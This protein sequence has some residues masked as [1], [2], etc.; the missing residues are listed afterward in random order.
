MN[1]TPSAY[2]PLFSSAFVFSLGIF[3][4]LRYM[5][6][7]RELELVLSLF[8]GS[9]TVWLFGTFMMFISTTDQ[10]AIFWDR[11]VYSGVVFVPTLMHHFSI[12]FADLKKQ[13]KYLKIGYI[14]SFIFLLLSWTNLFVGDL[15]KYEWGSHTKAHFFHHI[16]IV[17]FFTYTGVFFVN[18]W[19]FYK[20][21]ISEKSKNQAKYVF[22]AFL[23]LIALGAPAYLPA[24]GISVPPFPFISGLLFI[25]ILSYSILKHKLLDVKA[26]G[27]IF[28][29]FILILIL[30]A[31][32]FSSSLIFKVLALTIML[33]VGFFL[34]NNV[35]R[36]AEHAE[37][38]EK[39]AHKLEQDKKELVDLDRMKDEFLQMATHELN[40]PITV[41]Q[42]KM[43]MAI[44]E[45]YVHLNKEQKDYFQ[46]VMTDTERLAHLSK[47]IL[48]VAR[49]D[50]N[51]LT[52]NQ[53]EADLNELIISIV[54][55][56]QIKA[57]E[58]GITVEYIKPEKALPKLTIDQS[59][60]SEVIT[61]LIN[62]AIK[63]T[64]TGGITVIAREEDGDVVVSVR[65]TGI[66]M[67]K[68]DQKHLFEKF[69]Q[70]G[71]FDPDNP[72]EQ[73]GTGLG[74]YISKNIIEIHGGK[75]W[76]ESEKGEGS[77]FYFSLP[78]EYK[79]FKVGNGKLH[80]DE[81]QVRVL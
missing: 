39:L 44:R 50:Q 53:S 67:E 43:D 66:G 65:D 25:I 77:T 22:W 74:L 46:T 23:I 18:I 37:K 34:I 17:L 64:G 29:T 75:I 12:A 79:E 9:V 49:I 38:N 6:T 32:L 63:F 15:Y 30:I 55:G 7:R 54:D 1:F 59:K 76:L 45:D 13:R 68:E 81:D 14:V 71:R 78:K 40:T 69:Y 4:L 70:V 5:R 33:I 35:Q 2:V 60:I 21:G 61:N 62:N 72:Q 26:A 41:I 52:I 11:F 80:C 73:Q 48:N 56:F 47:D 31:N 27:A 57:K 28:L 20:S 36:E 19:K 8:C 58:K 3:T 10:Q 42:G 16:F 51:R 24:Y